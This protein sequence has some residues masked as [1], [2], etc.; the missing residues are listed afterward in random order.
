[1]WRSCAR[2][3]PQSRLRL[4]TSA[5]GLIGAERFTGKDSILSGPAGGV[6]GYARAAQAAG[7]ERAIGFDMGG[8]STDVSCFGGR[9]ELEFET[10]KAGVRV[11]A[12]MLAIETVA[13]GGG[14]I[15]RFDGVKLVV[16]P[17][18]AGA[19]PGPACYGRG[20]PLTVTDLNFILGRIPPRHFP[21][22]LER[23]A[24]E[25]RLRE[26][27]EEVATAT[28]RNYAPAAMAED[29]L[30]VAVATM[31]KAIRSISVAKGIDPREH[32]LVAFGGA[33]GQH[34]CAIAAELGMT[35]ILS[36]PDAGLLSAYGIGLAE[37]SRHAAAGV[38]RPLN[39]DTLAA[40]TAECERLAKPLGEELIADGAEGS[41]IQ[42]ERQIEL[43]YRGVEASLAVELTTADECT[44][45]F[46]AAHRK[47]Y[48]YVHEGRELEIVA[49]RVTVRAPSTV[50]LPRS[51]RL[52]QSS[53]RAAKKFS[54]S[55]LAWFG[56][57]EQRVPIIERAEL[58]PGDEIRG[59]AIVC[60]A[61]STLV[62]EPSWQACVLSEGELLVTPIGDVPVAATRK[63]STSGPDPAT[64]EIFNN[65]LA[66]IA[67]QM[68]HTL[69]NTASSVN[70]KERLDFSCALFT[71]AGDLVVNAPHIPVHLGAMGQT[72]RQVI[73]DN[74]HLR[75]GDV[76]VTNDPF[77]GGSHLPDITV[78]T[79]VHDRG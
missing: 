24:V 75:P 52:T 5:G 50:E 55:A 53:Q 70:V 8:T 44:A 59:P 78:V 65:Q 18:S 23:G 41:G 46:V 35:S 62:I 32:A 13:A 39:A 47:L 61:A 77:G 45:A 6:V 58:M 40:A 22:P 26:L 56:G 14:S 49:A 2:S 54:E 15:C 71:A 66:G 73:A 36:H 17:E 27:A 25:Q 19:D 12:P 42:V 51:L 21:L 11:V 48:G 64:L 7:F 29:L 9:Y 4:I 43:R 3:L 63:D 69:R 57:R 33:G 10:E 68:G 20:G 37:L 30:R 31:V 79:P 16:G 72:V 28:G 67:E 60:E 76:I 1:M 74:P 34:A 38:Y